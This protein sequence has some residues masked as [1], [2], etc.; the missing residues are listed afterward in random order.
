[1][2]SRSEDPRNDRIICPFCGYRMPIKQG[3]NAVCRDLYITCKNKFCK[4]TFEIRINSKI[5]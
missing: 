3:K 2:K 4:K 1:M 5:E